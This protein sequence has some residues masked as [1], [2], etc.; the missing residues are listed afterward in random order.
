MDLTLRKLQVIEAALSSAVS[1]TTDPATLAE[2]TDLRDEVHY[3]V[4]QSALY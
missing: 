4:R 1:I 2:L 3:A